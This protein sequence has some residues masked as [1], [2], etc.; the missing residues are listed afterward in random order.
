MTKWG[1]VFH[2]S[3]REK[4]SI[5]MSDRIVGLL[6]VAII[7]ANLVPAAITQIVGAG[8]TGWDAST[9]ALWAIIPLAI[10]LTVFLFFINQARRDS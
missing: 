8:Q 5:L 2:R 1:E 7:A 9:V 6:V 10:V 4:G 3:L